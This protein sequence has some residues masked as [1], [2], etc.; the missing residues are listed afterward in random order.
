MKIT[1]VDHT[2]F[3]VS[4]IERSLEF[5]EGLLGCEVLWRREIDEKAFRRALR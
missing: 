1:G 3:T 4:N 2:S 5:Y